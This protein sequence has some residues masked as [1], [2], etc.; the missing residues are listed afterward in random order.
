MS[1]EETDLM[2]T[3]LLAVIAALVLSGCAAQDKPGSEKQSKVTGSLTIEGKTEKLEHVFARRIERDLYMAG[4]DEAIAVL[5]SNKPLPM[6][7]LGVLLKDFSYGPTEREFLKDTSI[8]GLLLTIKK[9]EPSEPGRV[10]YDRYVIRAGRLSL[11]QRM[12]EAFSDFR[13]IQGRISARAEHKTAPDEGDED[14]S[15]K[16]LKYSYTANFD[17]ILQSRSVCKEFEGSSSS[18]TAPV[19]SEPGSAQGEVVVNGKAIK[20]EY[21]YARR[22]KVFFDEP[23]EKIQVVI[24]NRAYTVE[25]IASLLDMTVNKRPLQGL[26]LT[27]SNNPNMS[28]GLSVHKAVDP[29][30]SVPGNVKMGDFLIKPDRIS[31]KTKGADDFFKDKWSYSFSIDVPF[32]R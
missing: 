25:E 9:E 7:E 17:T 29:P 24:T 21:A 2:R 6:T 27:F 26:V 3:T 1:N 28:A 14:K 13:L 11:D 22:K 20:L 10:L 32:K 12:N 19:F 23:D 31:G 8:T 4:A 30:D 16:H 5:L 18:N 15:Q